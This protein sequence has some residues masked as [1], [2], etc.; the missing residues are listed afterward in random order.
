MFVDVD[1]P[2]GRWSRRMVQKD[3]GLIKLDNRCHMAMTVAMTVLIAIPYVQ[4]RR[5]VID[6]RSAPLSQV[7]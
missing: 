7:R 6:T 2:I 1:G 4:E 5:G 3:F